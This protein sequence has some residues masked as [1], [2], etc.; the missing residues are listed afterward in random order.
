MHN[1]YTPSK[2]LEII[3]F[4]KEGQKK[5]MKYLLLVD[6]Y[7]NDCLP[8]TKLFSIRNII[9]LIRRFREILD[10]LIYF[11]KIRIQKKKIH[12]LYSSL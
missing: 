6:F 3:I 9:I 2:L 10:M 11:Y 1:S 7:E 12:E 4:S 5:L 8:L